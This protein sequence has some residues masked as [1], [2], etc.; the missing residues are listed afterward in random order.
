MLM[1]EFQLVFYILWATWYFGSRP[2]SN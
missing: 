2:S 1:N